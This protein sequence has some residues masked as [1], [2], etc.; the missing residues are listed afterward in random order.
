MLGG[1]RT[2]VVAILKS[3]QEDMGYDIAD[4]KQIDHRYGTLEDVDELIAEL[5]KRDMKLMMD[6]VVKPY[7]QRASLVP[8]ESEQPRQPQ[9]RLILGEANSA[10][11]YDE[12][13]GEYYLSLSTPEQPDPNWKNPEI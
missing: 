12:K 6:L 7:E 5:R 11:T 13:T 10:W 8:G 3:P 9:A 2:V 4:Y 1:Q